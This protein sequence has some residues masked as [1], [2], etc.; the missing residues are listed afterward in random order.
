MTTMMMMM[1]TPWTVMS[2]VLHRTVAVPQL[3]QPSNCSHAPPQ[4]VCSPR[5]TNR[6][7]CFALPLNRDLCIEFHNHNGNV[8]RDTMAIIEVP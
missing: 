4:H 8:E 6:N 1:T 5:S 7:T 3:S 2:R